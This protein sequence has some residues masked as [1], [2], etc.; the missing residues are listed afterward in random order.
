MHAVAY[1]LENLK[2]LGYVQTEGISYTDQQWIFLPM[3]TVKTIAYFDEYVYKYLVGRAGQT[4]EP[5]FKFQNLLY[6]MRCGLDMVFAYE[7][8]K[9]KIIDKPIQH[10]LYAR[11]LPFVKAAY[12]TSLT[13]YN[14]DTKKAL[15][16]YDDE[17]R[18]HSEEIY[19][20][21][22]DKDISSFMGFKCFE[23]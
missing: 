7:N 1:R 18:K 6:V 16:N 15:M 8:H 11:L 3:I 17:L 21:I 2:K 20:L 12:V 22:G 9:V 5:V 13:H 4:M 10:Y 19:E 14:I 23:N